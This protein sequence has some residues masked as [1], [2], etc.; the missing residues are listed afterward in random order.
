M[1]LG[2][3]SEE[4]LD[5]KQLLINLFVSFGPVGSSLRM[6]KHDPKGVAQFFSKG[7]SHI[8]VLPKEGVV[9]GGGEAGG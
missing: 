3:A 7:T 2:N 6:F 5:F 4:S 8:V 1:G 9:D